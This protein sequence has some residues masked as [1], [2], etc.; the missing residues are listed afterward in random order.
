LG[1]ARRVRHWSSVPRRCELNTWSLITHKIEN[2]QYF[3][4]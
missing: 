2:A 1:K 4:C 3:W